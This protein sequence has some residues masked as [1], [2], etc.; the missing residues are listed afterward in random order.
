MMFAFRCVVCQIVKLASLILILNVRL[1][2]MDI[3]IQVRFPVNLVLL[4][5]KSARIVTIVIPVLQ[6]NSSEMDNV[7]IHHAHLMR[8]FSLTI[9]VIAVQDLLV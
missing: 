9:F 7:V 3:I 2:M 5:V 6:V 1:V 4:T 8:L